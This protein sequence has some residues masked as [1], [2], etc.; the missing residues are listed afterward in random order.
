V[1]IR[2]AHPSRPSFLLL[3]FGSRSLTPLELDQ[4]ADAIGSNGQEI[5]APAEACVLL[6]AISVH[7]SDSRRGAA[8]IISS[9]TG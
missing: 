7:S 8:T 4:D 2:T 3:D 5:D 6:A 9:S 1:L